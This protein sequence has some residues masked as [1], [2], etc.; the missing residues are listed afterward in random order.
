MKAHPI[1]HVEI[2]AA[3][4]KE[5]TQ[6]YADVFGWQFD[7]SMDFYPMFAAEG[8]PGGGF[9]K[10]SDVAHT[11]G[12]PLIFLGT[13]DIE[14]SLADVEAHGGKTLMPKT[15]IGEQ[16]EHGWF[17]VFTDPTGIRFALYTSPNQAS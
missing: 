5:A 9:V 12:V 2:P 16:G 6:F 7:H 13:D 15:S 14:E 8:G 1:V 10:Q 4:L 3:D 17:A 11:V